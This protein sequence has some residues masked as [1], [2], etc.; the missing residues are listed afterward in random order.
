[1]NSKRPGRLTSIITAASAGTIIEWYD[2]FIFGSLAT[3]ISTEFFPAENS[4]ASFLATLATFSAGLLVR[5]IGALYFGRLGDRIGRKYTFMITL[6]IMAVST[7]GIGLTPSYATIGVFAPIIVLILR[8]AQGLALGGEYGGAAVYVAEHAPDHRRGFFTSWIQT[9]SGLA[10]VLSIVVILLCKSLMPE[11]QWL[12]WGWRLPFIASIPL[13]AVSVYIRRRMAESPLFAAAKSSGQ[14]SRNPIRDSFGNKANLKIVLLAF[15]G[16][17]F[18]GGA[19]GWITFYAQSFMLKT[20]TLDFDQANRIV[21]IGILAGVPFFLLFGWLSDRI[22]RKFLM[23]AGMLLGVATFKPIFDGMHTVAESYRSHTVV[24]Q[25]M[26]HKDEHRT[27]LLTTEYSNGSI[28]TESVDRDAA[29]GLHPVAKTLSV[30][31]GQLDAWRLIGLIFSLQLIFTLVYGPLGAYMV[32]MFPVRIRYTSI[33][34]P[35]HF[36]FGIFGGLA[37]Y[38]ATY[39]V[40]K[41]SEAGRTDFYLAGISYPTILTAASFIIGSIYLTEK[42]S[43]IPTGFANAA[44]DQLKKWLGIV[45]MVAGLFVAW[46]GVFEIGLPRLLSSSTEDLVFGSILTFIITPVSAAGLFLFGL[47][48]IRGEY[49][50]QNLE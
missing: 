24:S 48:A 34:F 29:P 19:I 8:L 21:I 20:L 32:E 31:V 41:A 44:M 23:M 1:M 18:G 37:P 33:S 6:S 7:V 25:Q 45:W 40:D 3:I 30:Q 35:Y 39:F 9:T 12:S 28:V 13:I 47:Y 27:A 26:M 5:P 15:L 46:F 38:F 16:L 50:S 36:G 10:F 43:V 49:S 2:F 4:M 11:T 17:T 22:G 42:R 14:I